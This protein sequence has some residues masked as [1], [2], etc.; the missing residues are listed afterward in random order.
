MKRTHIVKV[1]ALG[2]VAG[3]VT[4]VDRPAS[5]ME[6]LTPYLPGVSVGAAAGALPPPGT[7]FANDN[8]FV[9]GGVKN[10][11]GNNVGA[12]VWL[13]V[14]IPSVLYVP[15]FQVLGASYA[16]ALVVPYV[17]KG[18]DATG[19]GAPGARATISNGLFNTIIQPIGLSWNLHNG[20]F[21]STGLSIYL[22][23][24]YYSHASGTNAIGQAG[25]QVTSQ[26]SIANN[27]WTFEP[28]AAISYLQ[29]DWNLTLHAVVDVNSE[30]NTTNYQSGDIFYLDYTATK[31]F[32]KWTV[33]GGGNWTQQFTD[34]TISGT[35]FN[36][37]NR[38]EN[39]LLGP[40][41]GY[42]FG[43][44]NIAAKA[45]FGVMAENAA[46]VSFYHLSFAFPF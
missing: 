11:S 13:D 25:A 2:L 44:V 21:V 22:P 34:D 31:T 39:L 6:G 30:N 38:E 1:A 35:K 26:A 46:N 8:V 20:F 12:N 36:D 16:A 23:D 28:S 4:I 14:E 33:G 3:A 5:A 18:V 15:N 29:N 42:D 10:N 45:M 40:Y 32:G 24:G 41:V 19:T 43:P 7:Y 27:F 17:F 9:D 37:G